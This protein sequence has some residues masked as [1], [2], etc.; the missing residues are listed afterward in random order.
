M[1]SIN[2]K[3]VAIT[4]SRDVYKVF[5]NVALSCNVSLSKVI[6]Y[7]LKEYA[8]TRLDVSEF[9]FLVNK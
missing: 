6:D 1:V 3:R 4:L 9:K 2:N 5:K 8:L 7:S